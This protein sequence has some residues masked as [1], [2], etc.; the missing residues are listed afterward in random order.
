MKDSGLSGIKSKWKSRKKNPV[1]VEKDLET[2]DSLTGN[3]KDDQFSKIKNS[4]KEQIFSVDVSSL[5]D[6]SCDVDPNNPP[7]WT[8]AV[9][10]CGWGTKVER[11]ISVF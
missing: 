9:R 10:N 5:E 8:V 3:E 11:V 4:R 1:I 2:G 6:E 7:D